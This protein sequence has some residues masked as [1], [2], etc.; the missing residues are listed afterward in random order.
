M[1][2]TASMPIDPIGGGVEPSVDAPV[3]GVW[4][5]VAPVEQVA[6]PTEMGLECVVRAQRYQ[7]R[8]P[9]RGA[10]L[11]VEEIE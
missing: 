1:L 11:E 10:T 4:D 2:A 9:P 5:P 3:N 7:R 8:S 6:Q